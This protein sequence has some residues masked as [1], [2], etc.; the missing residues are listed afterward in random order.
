[1][2]G[3][4][5]SALMW[6]LAISGCSG[7][8]V[9]YLAFILPGSNIM[10]FLFSL[11]I[12]HSAVFSTEH[13]DH[14]DRFPIFLRCWLLSSGSVLH[15]VIVCLGPSRYLQLFKTRMASSST[16]NV[17]FSLSGYFNPTAG[18][19]IYY[20]CQ[21]GTFA[22]SPGSTACRLAD[23]GAFMP[24]VASAAQW[25]CSTTLLDGSLTCNT[26]PALCITAV[27]C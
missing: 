2:L 5:G 25:S 15:W 18:T 10:Q 23:D 1:M 20:A 21:P 11:L 4:V 17:I 26:G 6:R 8:G 22:S 14:G 16:V 3:N 27:S 24:L 7:Y 9:R 12:L 13:V 19:N